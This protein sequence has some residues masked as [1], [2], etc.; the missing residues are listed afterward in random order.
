MI[1]QD[2]IRDL[3]LRR[4]IFEAHGQSEKVK[5]ID[6]ELAK[7]RKEAVKLEVEEHIE[8]AQTNDDS[9]KVL[10]PGLETA[11]ADLSDVETADASFA[12]R[13]PRKAAA[14]RKVAARKVAAV[15]RKA[16]KEKLAESEPTTPSEEA[17]TA[18]A[19]SGTDTPAKDR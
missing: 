10:E 9:L 11:E 8:Q 12:E 13:H 4:S 16:V 5:A 1:D 17:A 15:T 19:S 3:K 7:L 2:R 14:V 18:K 6:A